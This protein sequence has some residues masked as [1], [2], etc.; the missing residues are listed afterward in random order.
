MEKSKF[1]ELTSGGKP[2]IVNLETIEFIKEVNDTTNSKILNRITFISG[3]TLNIDETISDLRSLNV[4]P[5]IVG[6]FKN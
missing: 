4:F 6:P 5:G 2:T 3:A 1:V